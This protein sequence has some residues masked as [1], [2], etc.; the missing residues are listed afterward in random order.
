GTH[1]RHRS[2]SSALRSHPAVSWHHHQPPAWSYLYRLPRTR[3]RTPDPSS[4][5]ESRSHVPAALAL[6]SLRCSTSRRPG[7]ASTSWPKYIHSYA[8]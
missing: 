1:H 7:C 4:R 3:R 2:H 6:P 5:N 8:V